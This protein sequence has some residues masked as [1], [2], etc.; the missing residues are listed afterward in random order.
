MIPV[1]GLVG[2]SNSGKTT[3]LVKIIEELKQRNF[4]VA[5]IKHHDHEID[6]DKPGKDTWR[7][8]Q[9]GADQVALI[10]S[11]KAAIFYQYKENTCIEA[12]I[13]KLSGVD[14]II[15]EG[16]KYGNFPQIEIIRKEVRTE[17]I[18]NPKNLFAVA[19][20]FELPSIPVPVFEIND[21]KGIADLIEK[22]F[23]ATKE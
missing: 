22:K 13:Q 17:I 7:H 12:V 5:T 20:D 14:I 3:F 4:K 1:V 6:I 2:T 15:V 23:L 18:S 11:N 10:T 9:A 8:T 19:S 21:I 16:F